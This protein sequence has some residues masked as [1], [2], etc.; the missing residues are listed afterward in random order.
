MKLKTFL[1]WLCGVDT[2]KQKENKGSILLLLFICEIT[3]LA[4]TNDFPPT[5]LYR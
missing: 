2:G 3:F 5:Y 1:K 4:A